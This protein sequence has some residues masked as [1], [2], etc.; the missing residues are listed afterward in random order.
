[1]RA[2]N[3]RLW[4]APIAVGAVT[5]IGLLA[6]LLADGVW[7]TVSWVGLAVPVLVIAWYARRWQG[8]GRSGN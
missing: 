5:V 6:G 7:N 4:S 2:N 8:R 3:V 1:M